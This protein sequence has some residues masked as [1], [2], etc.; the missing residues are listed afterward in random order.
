MT[1]ETY[2]IGSILHTC[3]TLHTYEGA[4]LQFV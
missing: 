1:P 2:V 3:P 4:F